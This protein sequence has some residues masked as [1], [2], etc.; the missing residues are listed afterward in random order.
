[1]LGFE[2]LRNFRAKLKT[3]TQSDIRGKR[4]GRLSNDD[5]VAAFRWLMG[6]EPEGQAVIDGYSAVTPARLIEDFATSPE[7]HKR[8]KTSPYYYFHS[9]LDVEGIIRAHE[10]PQRAAKP[11][12]L[13]NFLG[14][15]MNVAFMPPVAEHGGKVEGLPIPA[16]WHAEMAEFAAA[17]RAVDL[18]RDRF[19]MIELGCGWGCWMNNTAAAAR[20]RGLKIHLIGVEGDEGHIGFAR[21]ALATNGVAPEDYMLWHGIAGARSGTALFPRQSQSGED[22]G[23]EPRFDL[24]PDARAELLADGRYDEL[25]VLA[26]GDI[27]GAE[28][29]IDLLHMDI[30]GGEADFVRDCMP[31]LLERVAYLVI[32]T[33]SR[34]IEGRLMTDLADAGWVLEIERPSDFTIT[35]SGPFTTMDGIQGWRNPRLVSP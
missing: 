32:G 6:R 31:T 8:W 27:V 20:H 11:G 28:Q 18:A 35:A 1:M 29:R 15:A 34:A 22:W 13:V 33:H 4:P 24:L 10:N 3:A 2:R 9:S 21:E 7:F 17:L 5:V 16:N 19:T 25:P 12:H 26:L 14:V 23:L 30:Q